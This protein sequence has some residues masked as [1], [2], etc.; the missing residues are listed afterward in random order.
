[1]TLYLYRAAKPS[2]L[3]N[4]SLRSRLLSFIPVKYEFLSFKESFHME[5]YFILS[6]EKDLSR[7]TDPTGSVS[8]VK[9]VVPS[10][11]KDY[12][13][14]LE[15]STEYTF[16]V[17]DFVRI[18]HGTY[19][20]L[21]GYIDD[22]MQDKVVVRPYLPRDY[23]GSLCFVHPKDVEIA[24]KRVKFPQFFK[25]SKEESLSTQSPVNNVVFVVDASF[26]LYES[27][28]AFKNLSY[29]GLATGGVFGF[30][31]L[32]TTAIEKYQP[33]KII[34]VWDHDLEKKREFYPEY[35]AGRPKNEVTE[36]VHNDVEFLKQHLHNFGIQH[37][38][39]EYSE[40]DDLI[41]YY[42]NK[43]HESGVLI[44]SGDDD[45]L[46]LLS[47]RVYILRSGGKILGKNYVIEKYGVPPE[48][49]AFFR[50]IRGDRSDNLGGIPRFSSDKLKLMVSSLRDP[51]D[52]YDNISEIKRRFDLSD[53]LFEKLVIS[54]SL[55]ERNYRLMRLDGEL[56]G[57]IH[58]VLPSWDE[59]TFLKVCDSYGLRQLLQ[60][61][62]LFESLTKKQGVMSVG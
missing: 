3:E 56:W 34:V 35:K 29:Q 2:I 47:N 13:G 9:T 18:I 10:E 17:G 22:L 53:L 31:R 4:P 24:P 58:E 46:Q 15:T 11:V 55:V 60:K 8:F 21:Y 36:R 26:L 1:M 16:K 61:Q 52:M 12:V 25:Q 38:Y 5:G 42:V 19:R 23:K 20:G 54:Q 14:S 6:S 43:Y 32:I 39:A 41:A 51:K 7:F 57:P 33:K 45:I 50:S 28:Y 37:T 49:V 27:H 30:F 40:A 59:K 48:E 62:E 44:Y